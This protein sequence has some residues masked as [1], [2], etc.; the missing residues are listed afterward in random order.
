MLPRIWLRTCV[1]NKYWLSE[2]GNAFGGYPNS[3][4]PG[5]VRGPG[6]HLVRLSS[7]RRWSQ[8]AFRSQG[9][10]S[11]GFYWLQPLVQAP[12][13]DEPAIAV[14]EAEVWPPGQADHDS[15]VI[16]ITVPK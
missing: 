7:L 13:D 1:V 9:K 6:Q 3:G 10:S 14:L 12:H 2:T 15:G 11:C 5:T 8:K 4:V 16:P